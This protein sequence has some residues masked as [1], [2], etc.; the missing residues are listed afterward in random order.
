MKPA[1]LSAR[2]TWADVQASATAK[3]KGIDNALPDELVVNAARTAQ[4]LESVEALLGGITVSSWFR[5][6]ALNAAVGG[7]PDSKHQ[8]ALAAD[9]VPVNV[10]LPVAFERIRASVLPYDQLIVERVASG[11]AWIHL[12]LSL[13]PPRREA[14]SASGPQLGGAMTFQRVAVG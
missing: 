1:V 12:G 2:F 3:A 8:L 9:F 4:I 7:K 6:P 14:L 5:C 11:S 10:S 13:A